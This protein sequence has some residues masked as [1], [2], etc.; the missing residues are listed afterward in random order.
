MHTQFKFDVQKTM[1]KLISV[2]ASFKQTFK[3]CVGKIKGAF[4][5]KLRIWGLELARNFHQTSARI[6]PDL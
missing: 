4:V 6:R 3:I 5:C 1:C 2:S